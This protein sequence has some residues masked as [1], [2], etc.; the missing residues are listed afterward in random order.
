M[1]ARLATFAVAP[2]RTTIVQCAATF[3]SGIRGGHIARHASNL[4]AQFS[5]FQ[6]RDA[7]AETQQPPQQRPGI[8]HNGLHQQAIAMHWIETLFAA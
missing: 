1:L 2:F 4:I 8:R 7:I 6:H 3:N 5:G